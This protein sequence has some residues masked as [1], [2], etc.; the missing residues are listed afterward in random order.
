MTIIEMHSG[1]DELMDKPGSP[2]FNSTQKD[3]YL[4][5]AQLEFTKER[6]AEFEFNEK[7][8][9]DILPLVRK[10]SF[11]TLTIN[12]DNTTIPLFMYVLAMSVTAKDECDTE[13]TYPAKPMRWDDYWESE[14]DPFNKAAI[15]NPVY[16]TSNNGTN[17]IIEIK[18]IT[19]LVL[20]NMTYLKR[21]VQVLNDE[22][23]PA[24]NVN[25]ELPVST[26]EEIVN[27]AVRKMLEVSKDPNYQLHLNEIANQE[28][29]RKT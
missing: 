11:T 19:T 17:D 7:R 10:M 25:C 27:L 18:G 24:N 15:D 8:R 26:H 21:P 14:L 2:Y 28:S 23:T 29:N 16:L 12:L 6:Y 13:F 4:N 1:I 20:V 9:Q 3:F 5:L 22:N